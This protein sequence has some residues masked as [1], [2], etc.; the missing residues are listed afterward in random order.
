MSWQMCVHYPVQHQHAF[1][2]RQ[3]AHCMAFYMQSMCVCT[4][5]TYQVYV[6]VYAVWVESKC[7]EDVWFLSWYRVL[8][9]M[10]NAQM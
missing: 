7:K 2:P 8:I 10:Y 4:L 5:S 1:S 9:C 3:G 6:G